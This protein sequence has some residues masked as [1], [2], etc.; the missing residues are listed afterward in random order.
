M[1]VRRRASLTLGLWCCFAS[2]LSFG[3]EPLKESRPGVYRG[4]S[5]ALYA[6]SIKTSQ[7]VA[8]RDGTRLAV[9][10]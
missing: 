1:N 7:Y 9:D 8:V 4:Y 6:E 10:I 3:A 2:A 5:P